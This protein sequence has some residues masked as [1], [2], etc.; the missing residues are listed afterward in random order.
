MDDAE[1]AFRDALHRVDSVKIPLPSLE[2]MAV[3]RTRG[4]GLVLGRWVAA[5]ATV[6]VVAGLGTWVL[7]VRGQPVS[8]VPAAPVSVAAPVKLTGTTW[9]AVEFSG[10]PTGFA[11]DKMP[12]LE[13]KDDSTFSGGDPCNGVAGTYRLVGSDLTLSRPG[14]T[15]AV[16]CNIVQQQAFVTVL[17]DTRRVSLEGDTIALLDTSGTVLARFR[18]S[19]AYASPGPTPTPTMPT[20]LPTAANTP[21]SH[22][23][24]AIWF[25]IRNTSTVD[26]TDVY[27]VFPTGEK[28]HYGP[29]A[30]GSVSRYESVRQAF[31][32]GYLKVTT[33]DKS[34]VYQPVDYVGESQLP[35]G[36]YGYALD[37]VDARIDLTLERD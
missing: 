21:I 31:S 1:R 3:R 28:V 35:D 24:P 12:F 20:V 22:P 8:A 11:R 6:A 33:A 37:I 34:Y 14:P 19:E 2:P 18:S 10:R 15:T 23:T 29:L 9:I 4:R 5:A 17:A 32:Y 7:T 27:A 36:H 16:A 13:F 25:R 30:A 26:F